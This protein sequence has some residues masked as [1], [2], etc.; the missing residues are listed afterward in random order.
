[1]SES[2][3]RALETHLNAMTPAV[4]TAW[5]G[6]SFTPATGVPY[7]RAH[8]LPA[9][10]DNRQMGSSMRI[11]RGVFQ[12]MLCYP[13]GVGSATAQARADAVVAWFKRGTTLSSGG[14][15]TIV[16]DTPAKSPAFIDTD[17]YVVPISIRYQACVFG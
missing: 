12:V 8:M 13:S 7:Q 16:T 17:R 10:P 11:E 14:V 6:V 1:M 9:T 2:I 15:Q 4:A 3:R 5:E